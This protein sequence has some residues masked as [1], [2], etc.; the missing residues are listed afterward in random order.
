MV[1]VRDEGSEFEGSIQTVWR[2]LNSPELHGPA[3]KSTRNRAVKPVGGE[4]SIVSMERNW[5]GKWVRVRNR[6][7]VLPPLA[8]VTE[9][10]EGPFAGSKI[11][12]VYTPGDGNR[13]RVDVYGEFR[14]P[15]LKEAEIDAAA[16]AWL[17]ESFRE[18]A[19]AIKTFQEG[20]HD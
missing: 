13:T 4:V 8:T 10:E 12:T 11:I 9:P 1:N 2:Y 14:S 18:D 5:D 17:E 6:L 15:V 19:P 20:A 3:H 7:T 16:R